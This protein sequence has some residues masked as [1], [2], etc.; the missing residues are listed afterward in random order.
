MRNKIIRKFWRFHWKT[1]IA[2]KA[3]TDNIGFRIGS[4]VHI[5]SFNFYK[6]KIHKSN[7]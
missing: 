7:W 1:F 5:L 3:R 2:G 6:I 4:Y